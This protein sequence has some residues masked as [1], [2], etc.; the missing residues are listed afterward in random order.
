FH[1]VDGILGQ[2]AEGAVAQPPILL[3]RSRAPRTSKD[4]SDCSAIHSAAAAA[5]PTLFESLPLLETN[6]WGRVHDDIVMRADRILI[7][8]GRPS[9]YRVAVRALAGG[10]PIVPIGAFGGAGREVI[11]MLENVGDQQNFPKYEYR[12]VLADRA[13]GEEQLRTSLF[14]LGVEQDPKE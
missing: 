6:D 2:P 7:L 1:V 3:V 9:S 10:R 11:K 12:R 5:R 14:A 13:W 8:G 4:D